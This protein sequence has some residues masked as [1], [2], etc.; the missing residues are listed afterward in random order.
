MGRTGEEERFAISPSR[1][2]RWTRL[3][4][5]SAWKPLATR[6]FNISTLQVKLSAVLHLLPPSDPTRTRFELLSTRFDPSFSTPSFSILWEE[7]SLSPS[8]E[9][10]AGNPRSDDLFDE[11]R[12]IPTQLCFS[13]GI[14]V[15]R[16]CPLSLSLFALR[17]DKNLE[18]KRPLFCSFIL[19]FLFFLSCSYWGDE[20][21]K[22]RSRVLK[23]RRSMISLRGHV[24]DSDLVFRNCRLERISF[25]YSIFS[26]VSFFVFL[27][28]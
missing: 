15:S 8:R 9:S 21:S 17:A 13:A 11:F 2:S 10:L 23:G 28:R 12:R 14:F 5:D 18:I 6:N 26:L 7:R 4:Q 16:E 22:I 19:F 27:S 1:P 25:L 24:N 20:D 3:G